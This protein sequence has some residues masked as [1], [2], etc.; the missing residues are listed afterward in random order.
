MS[1]AQPSRA[2]SK[3]L[4]D[5]RNLSE[6]FASGEFAD[7]IRQGLPRHLNPD[8]M[9]R[10][11]V[12]ATTR[13]PDL[14]KVDMRQAIGGFLTLSQLG[15]QPNNALGEAYMIPFAK[16]KW[17]AATKTRDVVGYDFNIVV[18]YKGYLTLAYRSGL[19]G[20][21]H[22]DV[23]WPGDEFEYVYGS[24]QDLMHRPTGKHGDTATPNYA[25]A[26]AHLKGEGVSIPPFRVVPWADVLRTRNSSQGYQSA[27]YAKEEAE[28]K[29]WKLPASYTE[30][31]WVK[32]I[33]PMAIKTAW[34]R[35]S[36]WVPKS[37][38][39]A[40]AAQ[41]DEA[42]DRGARVDFSGA[43][44]G[45]SIVE[46]TIDMEEPTPGADTAFGV[47]EPESEPEKPAPKPQPEAKPAAANPTQ[48]PAPRAEPVKPTVQI[49][50]MTEFGEPDTDPADGSELLLTSCA[51]FA[52][53]FESAAAACQDIE[54]LV[55]HNGNG[56]GDCFH[57]KGAM[58]RIDAAIGAARTRLAGPP[59]QTASVPL[60]V[61]VPMKD[62]KPQLVA[63]VKAIQAALAQE[64]AVDAFVVANEPNY[65]GMPPATRKAIENL[66]AER[67]IQLQPAPTDK[68]TDD[69]PPDFAP[70]EGETPATPP[71]P[72]PDEKFAANTIL[73]I[74]AT[75]TLDALTLLST[76]T[77]IVRGMQGLKERR[78][79]LWQ[80]VVNASVAHRAAVGGG[81]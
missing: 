80:E 17:N 61:S 64:D 40:G 35:L 4:K 50:A 38:E 55:E 20:S 46:G 28:K 78:S 26:V 51:D 12:Q 63:Y 27:L 15:L 8:A 76:N 71:A 25:Y 60:A 43:L 67:T 16:K 11:F 81:Q 54:A 49:W 22:A 57:D 39:M 32:H 30:A 77:A 19:V 44:D 66:I 48:Q 24:K 10:T 34:L 21:V 45:G 53:W 74:R 9:L 59:E 73:D 7:R 47:R 29:N 1:D 75:K 62:G 58:A 23:V 31:P 6:A 41:L 14:L 68:P 79:D 69:G 42:A 5:C 37:L 3:P 70:V 65:R 18:G 72:T 13:Q 56:L 33:I 36:N 2:L 52:E